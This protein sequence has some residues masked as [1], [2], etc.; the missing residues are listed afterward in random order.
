MVDR[1]LAVLEG[2]R[3]NDPEL[4][5]RHVRYVSLLTEV[6]TGLESIARAIEEAAK[7]HDLASRQAKFQSASTVVKRLSD[8]I[9]EWLNTNAAT[10]AAYASKSLLLGMGTL[11]LTGCGVPSVMAFPVLTFLLGGK[12][13]VDAAKQGTRQGK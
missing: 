6:R 11:F 2:S 8:C 1:E 3:P 7:E 13:L 4:L 9:V 5:D 10:V 12:V